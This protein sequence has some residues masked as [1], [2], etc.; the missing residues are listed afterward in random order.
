MRITTARAALLGATAIVLS[1]APDPALAQQ[2]PVTPAA[3]AGDASEIVV[4]ASK[5]GV[6]LDKSPV[7]ASVVSAAKLE[8][9]HVQTIQDIQVMVPALVYNDAASHGE[10]YIRG[11][12]S[13][14]SLAGAESSVATYVN[15]AYLQR[16][17]GGNINLIDVAD[18]QVLKGPQ[19][20]LYGRDATGGAIVIETAK[21]TSDFGGYMSGEGGNKGHYGF[22]GLLNAPLSPTVGLRVVADYQHLGNYIKNIGG[23][24]GDLGGFE[25]RYIRG[26]LQWKP[27]SD[28]TATLIADYSDNLNNSYP[29]HMRVQAPLC[30]AC[31]L[32]GLTVPTGFYTVAGSDPAPNDGLINDHDGYQIRANY[33]SAT[34]QLNYHGENFD[35]TSVSSYRDSNQY[36]NSEEDRTTANME[37]AE[38]DEQGPTFTQDIYL[39]THFDSKFN[40]L[41][42]AFY[43]RERNTM[44]TTLEGSAFGGLPDLHQ[45]YLASIDSISGYG[46]VNYEIVDGLKLTGDIRYNHDNKRGDAHNDPYAALI[47]GGL[48]S[49]HQGLKKGDFTPRGVISYSKAGQYF[50]ASYSI[51]R[52]SPFF[53]TPAFAP[54]EPLKEESLK[55]WEVG[56]KN[57]WF[58][59][60]LHTDLAAFYGKWS[61]IVV[62]YDDP[63]SG[64]IRAQNAAG[65]K[66]YGFEAQADWRITPQLNITL[67]A[68]YLH[69]K[70]TDYKT[71]A[72]Y[73]P[74]PN[75]DP[76]TGGGGFVSA[77]ED[78][79][80]TPLPRSPKFT[81]TFDV[82]YAM[83]VGGDWKLVFSGNGRYTSKFL[84]I[85]GGGGPLEFDVQRHFFKMDGSITLTSPSAGWGISLYATNLTGVHYFTYAATDTFGPFD[86]PAAPRLFGVRV[87]RSF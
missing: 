17:S 73:A 79:S 9:A 1:F 33:W 19:S 32:Y 16:Q 5:T 12:G 43:E 74:N 55:E 75:T 20:S 11:V 52:K 70:F 21:P 46:E 48:T 81:G 7:S 68:A 54:L 4:T 14:F 64:G 36:G 26:T 31:N 15:G 50:Y 62:Q 86:T 29:Q 65:A 67:G 61:D 23:A 42:G 57:S 22:T 6:T 63:A 47:A 59:G 18:V 34:L 60:A 72:V 56:A 69:N 66:T 37:Y 84:F 13:N 2:A 82:N 28:F 49:Y 40:F 51:G 3:P 87:K 35:V 80:G 25:N 83:P 58:D 24:G 8:A 44:T 30:L 27:S 71:A 38:V 41:V 53:T 78:L 85:S 39:R 77:V 76:A 10:A 45:T